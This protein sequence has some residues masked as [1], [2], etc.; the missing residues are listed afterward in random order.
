MHGITLSDS[1]THL[2][3]GL[4]IAGIGTGFIN[5]PLAS[6][7]VGVVEPARSGMASGINSTF[8]QVGTATGI[9]ALGSVFASQIRG[10]ITTRL[11]STPLN[12]VSSSI[13]NGVLSGQTSAPGGSHATNAAALEQ[14]VRSAADQG[15]VNGLNEIL[16]I[17]AILA[18]AAA[19]GCAFL[20]RQKDFAVSAAPGQSE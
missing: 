8:R 5:V 10:T 9:A 3:A 16:A 2:V 15:L 1:W 14:L 20:I 11:T 17:G 6:T 7:A 18:F 19:I 13:A 4:V 12:G